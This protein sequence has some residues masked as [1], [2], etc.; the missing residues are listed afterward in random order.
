[1]LGVVDGQHRELQRAVGGHG[2]QP[3]DAGGGLLGAADDAVEQLGAVL[4]DGADQVGAVVHGQVRLVVE[5]GLDVL[6]IGG[7]V[8]AFDGV[9]RNLVVR[10]QAGGHLVLGGERVGGAQHDI[11]AAEL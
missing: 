3:D 1:G 4:V 5:G 9:S 8:L 7:G 6:V 2:P 11:G 10:H